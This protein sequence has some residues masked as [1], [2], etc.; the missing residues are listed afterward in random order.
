MI[1][2]RFESSQSHQLS[3]VK[4][5]TDLFEGQPLAKGESEISFSMEGASIALTEKGIGNN[6]IISDE[7]IL[8]NVQTVQKRNGIVLSESLIPSYTEDKQTE[9]TRYNFTIEMETGTGKTYTYLRSIYELNKVY[10]FKK[11]VI[12]VPSVA[13]KEGAVKSLQIT[14]EHFQTL[15]GNPS[16]NYVMYDGRNY[17]SLKNF[18][19]SNAIQ[20]LV[21]NID[22]FAKDANTINTIRET[23]VKPIEYLQATNPIVIIDEP[24]RM[25]TDIRRLAIYNLNPLCTLRYSATH[26]N[27]YN[28]VYSLNPVQAYDL[29]LVKQIEVDGI[30]ANSDFNTAFLRIVGFEQ[31]KKSLKAMIAIHVQSLFDVKEKIVKVFIGDDLFALSG[32]REIYKDGYI[33]NSM[34]VADEK[35]IVEFSNGLILSQDE[36]VGRKSDDVLKYQIDRAVYHH[37]EKEV[38]YWK[39]VSNYKPIKVLTL[40][41]IDKVAN[42]REYNDHE[43]K[44]GKFAIWFEEIFNN[45]VHKYRLLYP[46]LFNP[47][48]KDIYFDTKKVHETDIPVLHPEYWNVSRIH[49]GY[50]SKDKKGNFKDTKGTTKDDDDTYTLIM[51]DKERL[52][53]LDEPL[54]FIFSHSALKEG[55]DNP[56][57]FQICTLNE[58]KSQEKKRQEIGRG[59]RLPVDSSGQRVQDKRINILTIIANESYEDFSRALQEEI[60]EETSVE[61][62]GRIKDAR[63]KASIKLSK[64]LTIENYPLLHDIWKRISHKTRYRVEYSTDELI[65]RTVFEL[66][67]F[68]KVPMVKRPI[69]EAR[70]AKLNYTGAGV[71]SKLTDARMKAADEIRYQIPD[72]YAYIQNRV[73]ITRTTIFEILKRS[74]RY[75]ELEINPQL[76]LEK[77]VGAIQ[78]TLNNLLVEGVKYEHINGQQY[79][80]ALFNNEEIETYLSNLFKV[81]KENKTVFNYIPVDSSIENNFARDC[82]ADEN[83]KFFFKL[84][85]EFKVAT[86]IGNYIPDWAVILE[87]NNRVYFVAE[88][89]STFDTQLLHGIEAMK[90]ECG[91]KHFALFQPLGVEYRVAVELKDLY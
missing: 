33:I 64:E 27:F 88:S 70:T 73:D 80:M 9:F 53:S 67:D 8:K 48:P 36:E 35:V 17:T 87:N 46:D 54:R 19:T 7:Q 51:R 55:W 13:I 32:G 23:G 90:I 52:L 12:V 29:G 5:I 82:E 66:K 44:K 30:T 15:Y 39:G 71:E 78:R 38:K 63:D 81:S 79:Q 62:T 40:F 45:Y 65:K 91:K 2:L 3:G 49:N 89:K 75:N 56:N 74:E 41:F 76:F 24:Q 58:S 11:F 68:N 86:P 84:P 50:F 47:S 28:L 21:I 26:R 1:K 34:H 59:L 20:I 83:V 85:R 16:I 18:A 43:V 69:L 10:G 25:E 77:V 31:K 42:Y 60:Q 14:H 6:L 22:S 4:A 37:F 61:F 72:V 57:V